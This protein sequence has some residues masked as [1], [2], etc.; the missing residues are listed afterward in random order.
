MTVCE[1]CWADAYVRSLENG[2]SQY[3]NYLDLLEERR[4][5]PCPQNTLAEGH[6]LALRDGNAVFERRR[7]K[8]QSAPRRE[9]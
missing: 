5:N 3:D 7:K 4:D 6:S 2:K 8:N 9:G 1:K